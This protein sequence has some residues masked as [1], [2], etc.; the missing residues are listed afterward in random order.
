MAMTTP[1]DFQTCAAKL[2]AIADSERL[3]IVQ[4]LFEGEMNV[5]ELSEALGDEIVKVSHHLGVL[6]HAGLV[7]TEKRGRYVI[8]S[9]CP[10]LA[11]QRESDGTGRI[12]NFGCC[13]LDLEAGG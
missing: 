13:V 1:D 7:C 4:C 9:L 3:R 10:E 2:K 11:P 12:L 6:R 8:Y 5:T